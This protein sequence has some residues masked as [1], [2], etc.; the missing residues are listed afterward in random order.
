MDRSFP[1]TYSILLRVQGARKT[2]NPYLLCAHMDVAPAGD[3]EQWLEEPFLGE[4][5]EQD[6][7]RFIFGRGAIDDKHSVVGILLALEAVLRDGGQPQRTLYVALGH[8]EEVR[9]TR[10]ENWHNQQTDL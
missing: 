5:V 1:N 7:G 3:H 10:A 9:G 2:T 6:G 4:V 8:D